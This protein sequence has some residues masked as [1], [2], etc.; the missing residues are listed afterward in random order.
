MDSNPRADKIID[1]HNQVRADP[2]SFVPVLERYLSYFDKS[3]QEGV[4]FYPDQ[5]PIMTNEGEKAVS[6]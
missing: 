1:L 5:T 4:I 6:S 2:K 3:K